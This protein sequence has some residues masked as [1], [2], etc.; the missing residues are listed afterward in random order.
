MSEFLSPQLIYA[1]GLLILGF[2][3]IL[4]EIFVIPGFN[5]FGILG[6]LT[7]CSGVYVAYRV[8]PEY[9]VVVGAVGLAGTAALIWMLVRQRAWSRL[10]LDN[11]TTREAGYDSSK[12][13]I[14]DLV[15]QCGEAVTP[16]RPAG[17]MALG[18]ALVDVV[19]EGDFVERGVMVEVVLVDGNRVVVQRVVAE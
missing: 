11:A 16:L 10:V 3:L 14:S 4:L 17:R 7:L 6:F 1:L 5:M 19:T 13:G 12:P 9:A 8:G 18:G 2:I 15:G